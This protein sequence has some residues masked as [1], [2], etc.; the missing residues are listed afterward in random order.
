[1]E[2]KFPNIEV[3]LTGTDGNAFSV[4]GKVKR[5]LPSDVRDEFMKEAMSGDYNNVLATAMLWVNV[6]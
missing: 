3:Q 1:M 4:I 6:R 5:A 2:T